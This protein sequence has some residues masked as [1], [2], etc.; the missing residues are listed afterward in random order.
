MQANDS[1]ALGVRDSLDQVILQPKTCL[2]IKSATRLAVGSKGS[3]RRSC[4][5]LPEGEIDAIVALGGLDA[6]E[7]DGQV[8]LLGGGHGVGDN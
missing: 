6:G 3:E 1:V 8:G 7:H 5:V 4:I 2:G